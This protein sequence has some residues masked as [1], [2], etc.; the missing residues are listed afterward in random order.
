MRPGL[1]TIESRRRTFFYAMHAAVL[2]KPY[3][4]PR[5]NNLY[6]K[7]KARVIPVIWQWNIEVNKLDPDTNSH[8]QYKEE[9]TSYVFTRK[10]NLRKR[11]G[12]I[13]SKVNRTGNSPHL[14]NALFCNNTTVPKTRYSSPG[15]LCSSGV[16]TGTWSILAHV[17]CTMD[18]GQ[19]RSIF[20]FAKRYLIPCYWVTDGAGSLRSFKKITPKMS[21]KWRYAEFFKLYIEL[22]KSVHPKESCWKVSFLFARTEIWS[23]LRNV[24][25]TVSLIIHKTKIKEKW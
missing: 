8:F 14:A 21:W 2:C 23:A 9:T 17:R 20:F 6:I 10:L 22:L 15:I 7:Q 16:E 11:K 25:K 19:W 13:K 12:N 5:V 4:V 24:L 18:T 3:P 1:F